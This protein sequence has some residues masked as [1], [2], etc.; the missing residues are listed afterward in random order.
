MQTLLSMMHYGLSRIL[1]DRERVC[2]SRLWCYFM[3]GV[4]QVGDA[5]DQNVVAGERGEK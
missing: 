5:D 2:L 1:K 4:S 3:I